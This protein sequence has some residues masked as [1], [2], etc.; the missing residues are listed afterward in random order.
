MS[1]ASSVPNTLTPNLLSVETC[2]KHLNQSFLIGR[3]ALVQELAVCVAIF[4]GAGNI[5]IHT[6]QLVK[7]VYKAAGYDAENKKSR[8]YKTVNRRLNA[9]AAL[10]SKLGPNVVKEWIGNTREDSMLVAI[11]KGLETH[12]FDSLDDVLEFSGRSNNRDRKVVKPI[13]PQVPMQTFR[14]TGVKVEIPLDTD[15]ETMLK[16]A[17]KIIDAARKK[18]QEELRNSAGHLIDVKAPIVLS[19]MH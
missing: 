5:S 14:V 9:S 19:T 15:S 2:I 17:A 4:A 1:S 11:S 3:R 6:K 10:Y 16:L 18:E 13:E 12:R 7:E 8:H